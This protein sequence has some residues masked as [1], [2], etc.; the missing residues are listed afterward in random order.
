[1]AKAIY[2]SLFQWLIEEL[3][4]KLN[5]SHE[6]EGEARTIKLLDIYGFEVFEHNSF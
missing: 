6:A 4:R 2:E 1:M 5:S 3:N